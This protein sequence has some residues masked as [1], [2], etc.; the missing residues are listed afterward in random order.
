MALNALAG[1]HLIRL[2]SCSAGYAY[3]TAAKAAKL[4]CKVQTYKYMAY[5]V[6]LMCCLQLAL[7]RLKNLLKHVYKCWRALLHSLFFVVSF[8]LGEK[9][10]YVDS[11][12]I[13]K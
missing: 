7:R 10:R 4:T 8:I 5:A 12:A 9:A 11:A 1:W 6:R 13:W 3:A 2:F